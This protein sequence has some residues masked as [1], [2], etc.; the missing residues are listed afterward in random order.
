MPNASAPINR[1]RAACV[2]R[3]RLAFAAEP[4]GCSLTPVDTDT[5]AQRMLDEGYLIA[6][7]LLFHATRRP[8][9]RRITR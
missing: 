6:P 9:H 8:H 1:H 2:Q 4:A 3:P 5:L 7:G